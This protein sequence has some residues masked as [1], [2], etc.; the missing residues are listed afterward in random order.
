MS[1]P[2]SPKK[3]SPTSPMN[4]SISSHHL[5]S[6]NG[7]R[8]TKSCENITIN[9]TSKSTPV[10][11]ELP[12]SYLGNAIPFTTK[13]SQGKTSSSLINEMETRNGLTF[14][15]PRETWKVSRPNFAT[16]RKYEN[17][18]VILEGDVVKYATL[19]G[20]IDYVISEQC[21]EEMRDTFI[22]TFGC[23]SEQNIVLKRLYDKYVDNIGTSSILTTISRIIEKWVNQMW[24]GCGNETI[25]IL[26]SFISLYNLSGDTIA[27]HKLQDGLERKEFIT[28]IVEEPAGTGMSLFTSIP[29]FLLLDP[30]MI[31]RQI[32]LI[33]WEMFKAIKPP[34]LY[35]WNKKDKEI[36]SPNIFN[37]VHH[38][39]SMNDVFVR[40]LLNA[41]DVSNRVSIAKQ[42]LEVGNG[43]IM[44]NNFNGVMEIASAFSKAS[45]HR[46]RL[47]K[48]FLGEDGN[49][50]FDKLE[51]I[52]QNSNNFKNLRECH[53]K[54]VGATLPY[55]G[56][57]LTD[58][59]FTE[60][61]TSSAVS[62]F[63]SVQNKTET[64]LINL[65][66]CRTLSKVVKTIVQYQQTP[67]LIK[68]SKEIC[69]YIEGLIQDPLMG[70]EEQFKMSQE[71]ESREF[72]CKCNGL[73]LQ[74][75]YE[76]E[77]Q[78]KYS[79]IHILNGNK[80][81]E[82]LL[83]REVILWV[84][85]PA[86]EESYN[87]PIKIKVSLDTQIKN[88]VK[89]LREESYEFV[90]APTKL[91]QV[92]ATLP[93]K[94]TVEEVLLQTENYRNDPED[95]FA[96]YSRID[97]VSLLFVCKKGSPQFMLKYKTNVDP[98]KPLA[99][100]IP[101]LVHLFRT[102]D[103]EFG[104]LQL[105]NKCKAIQWINPFATASLC[106]DLSK[107]LV[108]PV[109]YLSIPKNK[110]L[111]R[112]VPHPLNDTL[113]HVLTCSGYNSNQFQSKSSFVTYTVVYSDGFL[114]FYKIKRK[115]S[116]ILN[117]GYYQLRL[118]FNPKTKTPS[119][120]LTKAI[121]ITNQAKDV[122]TYALLTDDI[123]NTMRW[124]HTFCG[125]CLSNGKKR[126][127]GMDIDEVESGL[128]ECL[129]DSLYLSPKL[130]CNQELFDINLMSKM[131]IINDYEENQNVYSFTI[132]ELSQIL[133]VCLDLL[134][135]PF[136]NDIPNQLVDVDVIEFNSTRKKRIAIGIAKVMM[137]WCDR[138]IKLLDKVSCTLAK[139]YLGDRNKTKEINELLPK[140]EKLTIPIDENKEKRRRECLT[141]SILNEENLKLLQDTIS[142]ILIELSGIRIIEEGQIGNKQVRNKYM[143]HMNKDS[144]RQTMNLDSSGIPDN[145][146]KVIFKSEEDEGDEPIID[147][148][149]NEVDSIVSEPIPQLGFENE[150]LCNF[151]ETLN[152]TNPNFGSF[153]NSLDLFKLHS[154]PSS[155]ISINTF[156]R[157]KDMESPRQ[158]A[159]KGLL[160][161]R[162]K[163]LLLP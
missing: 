6:K 78:R 55:L 105:D 137:K 38:F 116:L 159:L 141:I 48:R 114:F 46:L 67:Y 35:A 51:E 96:V 69:E 29:N 63:E 28:T 14:N 134:P 127:L 82:K 88:I 65:D 5:L 158:T 37:F 100:A 9:Q 43:F 142:E 120:L 66:K 17:R 75:V 24:N 161:K 104:F 87:Y 8:M 110:L 136:I 11:P 92:G 153:K 58:L 125:D 47:T 36:N 84:L 39:N 118:V 74:K 81:E 126:M 133:I 156:K 3:F 18:K 106:C 143:K 111:K 85:L 32:T 40:L 113:I 41:P 152:Q 98:S 12:N 56:M 79:L 108:I 148:T 22:Y 115:P 26:Q 53:R 1:T 50:I 30:L 123:E 157:T 23:V 83:P 128:Y 112:C 57:F 102:K 25:H 119:I 154:L 42:I 103:D 60:D 129:I 27:E 33:E 10:T 62:A 139:A 61:M 146:I 80:S 45:I 131:E 124:Y 130:A 86:D 19:E 122:P 144:C 4:L 52:T 89:E 155:S 163:P 95:F 151:H 13:V 97:A 16:V 93:S 68:R 138:R 31:S 49:C 94:C 34:E 7:N 117:V 135:S 109:Q 72:I 2:L 59:L 145:M 21:D 64:V 44:L 20:L 54:A 132:K 101:S 91:L 73:N 160:I 99:H 150:F 70:D 90:L 76:F 71:K 147:E 77:H 121:Q 149:I 140:I 15:S 107:L 162:N